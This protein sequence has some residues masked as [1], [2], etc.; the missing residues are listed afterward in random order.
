MKPVD[1]S[2]QALSDLMRS[3]GNLPQKAVLEYQP[4]VED[5]LRTDCRDAVHIE[6]TLDGLLDFCGHDA[7]LALY[8][9]LCRRYLRIDEERTAFYIQAHREMW[10]SEDQG[11]EV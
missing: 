7:I 11:G 1:T 8:K 10:D 5:I 9:A 6:R 4:V 3:V 2:P